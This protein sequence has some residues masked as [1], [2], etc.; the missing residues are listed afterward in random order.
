MHMKDAM[1]HTQ[2]RFFNLCMVLLLLHVGTANS[3]HFFSRAKNIAGNALYWGVTIAPALCELYGYIGMKKIE[4]KARSIAFSCEQEVTE[5]AIFQSFVEDELRKIGLSDAQVYPGKHTCSSAEHILLDYR[6]MDHTLNALQR[7][8][9]CDAPLAQCE[10]IIRLTKGLLHHE[11]QHILHNDHQR[12]YGASLLITACTA[13]VS[14][15]FMHNASC[16]RMLTLGAVNAITNICLIMAF[17]RRCER[18]ADDAITDSDAIR[19]LIAYLQKHDAWLKKMHI[20]QPLTLWCKQ[21]A[22]THPSPASRIANLEQ[23]L[24]KEEHH[25]QETT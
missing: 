19:G 13:A 21:H 10:A 5:Y 1:F 3:A 15:F 9:E 17:K 4:D 6:L 2:Q 12:T 8:A 23:R 16:M 20:E 22:L 14:S 25:A 18:Q 24:Q 7:K 11:A